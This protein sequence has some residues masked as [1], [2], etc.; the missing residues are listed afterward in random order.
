MPLPTLRAFAPALNLKRLDAGAEAA[1]LGFEGGDGVAEGLEVG[2]FGG[3]A[4]GG[5]GRDEAGEAA[6]GGEEGEQVV[7][8][9]QAWIALA[10]RAGYPRRV[11]DRYPPGVSV[12]VL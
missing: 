10:G 2:Q 8:V 1:V 9:V 3:V 12:R 7:H 5:K 4:R 6:Q 11:G